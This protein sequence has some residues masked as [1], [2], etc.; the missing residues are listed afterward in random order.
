V[1]WFIL[2]IPTHQTLFASFP[3]AELVP[4]VQHSVVLP[5]QPLLPRRR[6]LVLDRFLLPVVRIE[7]QLDG[8]GRRRLLLLLGY[9]VGAGFLMALELVLVLRDRFCAEVAESDVAGA[10]RRVQHVVVWGDFFT[11]GEESVSCE[12][13]GPK[14]LTSCRRLCNLSCLSWLTILMRL[15][16]IGF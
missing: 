3:T 1:A 9:R 5:Y 2:E 8:R 14:G 12:V 10:V 4:R 13:E 16:D 11:A 7:F 6:L 15:R